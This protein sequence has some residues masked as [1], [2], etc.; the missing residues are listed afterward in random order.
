M[1]QKML[2]ILITLFIIGV[3]TVTCAQGLQNGECAEQPLKPFD[4]CDDY[5]EL[6]R[7]TINVKDDKDG[8]RRCRQIWYV[9]NPTTAECKYEFVT[10]RCD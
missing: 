4:K 7:C 1:Y 9:H 3:T 8:D 10:L 6:A 2:F 5:G